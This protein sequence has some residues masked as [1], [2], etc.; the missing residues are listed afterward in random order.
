M[1]LV[2]VEKRLVFLTEGAPGQVGE[3]A[4]DPLGQQ[5]RGAAT[6]GAPTKGARKK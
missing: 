4:G 5:A 3:A 6:K 1:L 2:F